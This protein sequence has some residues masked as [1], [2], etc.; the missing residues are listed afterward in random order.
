MN[1]INQ[2]IIIQNQT[3]QMMLGGGAASGMNIAG[4]N[5]NWLEP[6]SCEGLLPGLQQSLN[7]GCGTL[8]MIAG[9]LGLKGFD[10]TKPLPQLETA[11]I[12]GQFMAPTASAFHNFWPK[13]PSILGLRSQ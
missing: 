10:Q 5:S 7:S 13:S 12:F 11:G 6:L 2:N 1:D 8:Q 3:R 4:M 9:L